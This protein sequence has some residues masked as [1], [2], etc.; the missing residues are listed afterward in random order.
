[1]YSLPLRHRAT[2]LLRDIDIA[3]CA[4]VNGLRFLSLALPQLPYTKEPRA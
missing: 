4:L 3:S 2:S 1:M